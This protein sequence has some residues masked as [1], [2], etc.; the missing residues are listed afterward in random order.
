MDSLKPLAP[1]TKFAQHDKSFLLTLPKFMQHDIASSPGFGS[2]NLNF[3]VECN[4]FFEY[5]KLSFK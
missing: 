5:L 3:S 1:L 4:T 2:I